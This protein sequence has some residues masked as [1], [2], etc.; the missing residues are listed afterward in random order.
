MIDTPG[1]SVSRP[2]MMRSASRAIS[3]WEPTLCSTVVDAVHLE[4][5]LFLTLQLIDMG[6]PW[7]V[8]LNLMD[9]AEA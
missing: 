2:S 4:R 8:A 6:I 3:F 5:D 1:V 7:C 9:E